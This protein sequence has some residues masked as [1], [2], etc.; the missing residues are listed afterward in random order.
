MPGRSLYTWALRLLAPVLWLWMWRR[1]RKAGGQW[2]ILGV[3]RFGWVKPSAPDSQPVWVHAVSLGE[4]RAAEPLLRALLARGLPVLLT[5]MTATGRAEGARL[6]P[7]AIAQGQLRQAWL[8]Y[9][10]PGA[11]RRFLAR[12]RPRCGVLI[13]R[14][15]WPNL[16]AQARKQGVPMALA[17]ARFSESSLAQA[18]WLGTAL[19]EALAGLDAVLAQTAEDGGRLALAGAR[20]IKVVGNL[21]FDLTLP[22]DQVASGKAWRQ[23]LGRPVLA[24]ASTR[25][26]EEAMLLAALRSHP[27]PKVDGQAPLV[28]LIPR[29]PQRFDEVAGLLRA[30]GVPF[31]RRSDG[32]DVAALAD[33]AVLLGDS[34][35]E[36]PFYY[37]G[38]DVAIVAGSFAPLGG[39]NLIEACAAGVPVIVGSHTKN[40]AQAVDDAVAAG[41]ALQVLDADAAID[42]VS[43]LLNDGPRRA[44]MAEAAR[45]WQVSHVGATARIMDA[46]PLD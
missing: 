8:P 43:A 40:F 17:S 30:E 20:D 25:E 27:L 3:E 34:L 6:F 16:L 35:G 37:A 22:A 5:H 1:A 14:E 39:H 18:R 24:V 38:A 11:T 46:L 32:V 12:A 28:V 45:A 13:E 19:R 36:M 29:H 44:A 23:A 26:G 41:A 42:F 10:F 7:D 31:A 33:K 9:D 21:K 15:V 4:T 2:R